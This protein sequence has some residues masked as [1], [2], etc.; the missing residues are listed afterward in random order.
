VTI[1]GKHD[2]PTYGIL[3][4][5]FCYKDRDYWM[6][7]K[8]SCPENIT[9]KIDVGF[10]SLAIFDELPVRAQFGTKDV[11]A[12]EKWTCKGFDSFIVAQ[13]GSDAFLTS[14]LFWA[15]TVPIGYFAF[16]I[17]LVFGCCQCGTTDRVI[18]PPRFSPDPIPSL[19]PS[20]P[21]LRLRPGPQLGPERGRG[22][23]RK[24]PQKEEKVIK[25]HESFDKDFLDRRISR[26]RRLSPLVCAHRD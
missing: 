8:T 26:C 2:Q 4:G 20:A 22:R 15:I 23:G 1:V 7:F 24:S 12:K 18:S 17:A 14:K 11:A 6:T 16:L 21:Q 25:G 10:P 9:I 19:D 5:A 3:S 13:K